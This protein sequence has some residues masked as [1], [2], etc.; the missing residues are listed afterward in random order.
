MKRGT[1]RTEIK[2]YIRLII[3]LSLFVITKSDYRKRV[4]NRRVYGNQ[5]YNDVMNRF[6][7]QSAIDA[8]L[9][10]GVAKFFDLNDF[11]CEYYLILTSH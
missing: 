10:T 2:N 11:D 5:E 4:N 6:D 7:L 9:P 1:I 3:L 8:Q